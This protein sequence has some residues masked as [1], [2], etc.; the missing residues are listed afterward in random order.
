[1]DYVLDASA[2]IYLGKVRLLGHISKIKGKKLIPAAVY[3]EVVLRGFER[4]EPEAGYIDGLIKKNILIVAKPKK[5]VQIP[6]LS[7]ADNEV[8][9]LA[10]EMG[11]TAIIDEIYARDIAESM[12][13]EKHGSIWLVIAL[14]KQK[15]ISRNEAKKCI[16][17]MIA[18][19]FYLSIEMYREVEAKIGK[20]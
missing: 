10:G 9:S 8:L 15:A 5:L 19:G 2:L 1:M 13:I 6:S 16:D 20:L 17:G 7:R 11:A 18:H 14:L 4:R 12:G 3:G